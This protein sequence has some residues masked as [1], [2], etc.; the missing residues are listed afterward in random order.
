MYS[1][2][3][4]LVRNTLHIQLLRD[5]KIIYGDEKRTKQEHLVTF[6]SY[7]NVLTDSTKYG[8]DY[9]EFDLKSLLL[10]NNKLFLPGI[11]NNMFF[12]TGYLR[13]Y[14]YNKQKNNAYYHIQT[15]NLPFQNLEF[16]YMEDI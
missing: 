5:T 7:W 8:D 9:F 10:M 3:D 4:D 14:H 6:Q 15:I 16:Y 11:I 2:C 1:T 13:E 12:T